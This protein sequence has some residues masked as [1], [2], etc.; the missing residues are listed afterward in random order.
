M[1]VVFSIVEGFTIEFVWT[2]ELVLIVAVLLS[3]GL[4]LKVTGDMILVVA[5]GVDMIEWLKV[6]L[7]VVKFKFTVFW[8]R[9]V[10]LLKLKSSD[11][12][13]VNWLKPC[14]SC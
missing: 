4:K 13:C 8:L 12:L 6:L 2:I 5:V 10:V 14:D 1:K 7:M 3:A 11:P 9:E